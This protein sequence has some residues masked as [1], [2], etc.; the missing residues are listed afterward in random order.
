MRL[1]K[2]VA[3]MS[4][5]RALVSAAVLGVVAVLA[6]VVAFYP[7]GSSRPP[8]VV[9]AD[10]SNRP[11]ACLAADARTSAANGTFGAVWA[12]MQHGAKGRPINVQ[13][14]VLPAADAAAARPLLAGLLEQRCSL[15]VTVGQAI[16]ATVKIA[17]RTT[18][19][20]AVAAGDAPLPRG[21]TSLPAATAPAAVEQE[22]EQMKR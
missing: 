8:R 13:Q 2:S 19:F 22:I 14:L 11:T 9:A 18:R 10:V 12:A 7:S 15:I 21:V 1:P 17:P 5:P 6:A 4:R 16:A 20:T 3:S